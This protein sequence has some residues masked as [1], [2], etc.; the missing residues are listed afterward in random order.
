M[1]A[2]IYTRASLDRTGE[3]KSNDRQHEECIRL[4]DY[5]RWD[6][7]GH[8][9][10]VSIS[11]YGEKERPAWLRVLAS[12]EA[13]DVD[14]VVAYH[15]D[16]LTRNMADL[17]RLILLCE[18]HDVLVATATGDIDLTNDTG[19]MVARILAAV[20]RQEVER[21]AARQKLAHVQRRA[22]GRPW[23][24]VKMLGYTNHGEVIEKEAA[25]IRQAMQE[26]IDGGASLAEL[27]RRWQELGL[28][29]PYKDDD[30][31]WTPRGV[32]KVLTNPRLAGLITHDGVVLGQ[33]NWEPIVDET[34]LTL[35]TA[36]LNQP[37]RISG[38]KKRAGRIPTNL[39]TGVMVCA[40][41][42]ETVRA[43]S[44]RGTETY[45]CPKWHT[46]VP[47]TEADELVRSAIASAFALTSPDAILEPRSRA[48][49]PGSVATEI[50]TLRDRLDMLAQ[51]FMRGVTSAEA[52][53]KAAL[54]VKAQ[55]ERLEASV[56]GAA[57][58]VEW[59]E[60]RADLVR[61]FLGGDM[62]RQRRALA[63]IATITMHPTGGRASSARQQVEVV[64]K[65]K[66]GE[67]PAYSPG[68]LSA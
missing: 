22:E 49:D 36:Q 63:R 24:A 55:I 34:T 59:N 39:L 64:V 32:K 66:R 16:R 58:D 47:R 46:N 61:T 6:V 25:A 14:V 23:S 44:K 53:E 67:I 54:D 42:G 62:D 60:V 57:A 26:V 3:G 28:T 33:G 2:L 20:A 11:A 68:V 48:V 27:G 13:G 35:V 19:R 18:K 29:S 5:K 17:E 41:C 1:R 8:E 45:M 51:S 4:I 31:P 37:S 7:I 9:A 10:D 21:K 30:K 56:E 40:R 12:I 43:G 65:G 38:S 15:L 52:Y 50:A